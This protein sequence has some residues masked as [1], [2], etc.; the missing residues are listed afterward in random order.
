ME[1][2]VWLSQSTKTVLESSSNTSEAEASA[3]T[4]WVVGTRTRDTGWPGAATSR[5]RTPLVRSAGRTLGKNSLYAP[6]R[7]RYSSPLAPS[8][9]SCWA[10]DAAEARRPSATPQASTRLSLFLNM[11][12]TSSMQVDQLPDIDR[13]KELGKIARLRVEVPLELQEIIVR[14]LR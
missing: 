3:S 13:E 9:V 5:A 11:S 8:T 12:I 7:I 4:P 14:R 10:A 2:T 6:A 1:L